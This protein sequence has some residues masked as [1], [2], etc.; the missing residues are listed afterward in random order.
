MNETSMNRNRVIMVK[1]LNLW[2]DNPRIEPAENESIAVQRIYD[3]SAK[4]VDKS[5]E[6][7]MNLVF[8]IAEN[9][10]QNE[11]E[12][13]LVTHTADGRYVVRDANRRVSALKMLLDPESYA[14]I[15]T[16]QH[17]ERIKGYNKEFARNI[18]EAVTVA[19]FEESEQEI[20]EDILERKHNGPQSGVGTLPWSLEAKDR[21]REKNYF[22]DKL[23][24]PFERQ[25]GQSLTSYIGG[26]A[27]KSTTR[28]LISSTPA[29][30][31][32]QIKNPD[33][34]TPEELDKVRHLVDKLKDA[35]A[36]MNLVL[37]RMN[38]NRIQQV[39]DTLDDKGVEADKGNQTEKEPRQEPPHEEGDESRPGPDDYDIPDGDPMESSN[40]MLGSQWNKDSYMLKKPRFNELNIVLSALA[41][42]GQLN[43]ERNKRLKKMAILAPSARL[44]FELSLRTIK[45]A[46]AVDDLLGTGW[47][48]NDDYTEH[49]GKIYRK[50][51]EGAFKQYLSEH[52]IIS[53]SFKECTGIM[54]NIDMEA[55]AGRAVQ[56]AHTGRYGF[57]SDQIKETFHNAVLFAYLCEHYI[58][59]RE[60]K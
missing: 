24:R 57:T 29:Q 12:P 49:V 5:R 4:K 2:L 28:R 35:A 55:M 1:D 45:E 22:S 27:S 54:S 16:P 52:H 47:R 32:L 60:S 26:S 34:P 8:S 21:F 37:S 13:I 48:T 51:N 41:T 43:I 30:K 38:N 40:N 58:A 15:L 44:I 56:M 9:G 6:E 42:F 19:V 10:Y 23:E 50:F 7:F 53:D 14:T 3:E 36:D 39:I 33:N 46:A 31:H 59:Y 17:L 11:V 20:L 18:P 25:Y